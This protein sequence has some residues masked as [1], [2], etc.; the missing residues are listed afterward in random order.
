[1]KLI[2]RICL[3][4]CWLLAGC[5]G[6]P[7][8][9]IDAT[10]T[11]APIPLAGGGKSILVPPTL[12][13]AEQ[14]AVPGKSLVDLTL[15]NQSDWDVCYVYI[16]L[17]S[18]D[19]WGNDWLRTDE[20]IQVGQNHIF[21]I[22]PGYY[23]I[24]AEN[25][26]FVGLEEQYEVDLTGPNGWVVRNPTI[27][28]TDSFQAIGSWKTSGSAAQG[29]ISDETYILSG[30]SSGDIALATVGKNLDNLVLTVEA[31]PLEPEGAA[32]SGYGVICRVQPNGDGYLFLIRGDGMYGIFRSD[33]NERVPLVDWK[34]SQNVITGP[35]LNVV[36]AHCDGQD[37]G[38]RINGVTVEKISDSNYSS[39]DIGL[40]VLPGETGHVQAKFDNLV[41]IGP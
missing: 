25:C 24:R 18:D 40:A 34:S 23:D 29:A 37:L 30:S 4:L 22:Q 6:K 28:Y 3:G 15:E 11:N 27:L 36:E 39:R 13:P 20:I 21:K 2:I 10:P 38:L 19:T 41:V 33:H 32:P 1:M 7:S 5:T 12:S 16:S 9:S 31:T 26:D 14:T 8:A 17:P 35:R